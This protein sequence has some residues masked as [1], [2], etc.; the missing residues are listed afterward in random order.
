MS[1]TPR[2]NISDLEYCSY[3]TIRSFPGFIQLF[4]AKFTTIAPHS[5]VVF[6][7]QYARHVKDELS[8]NKHIYITWKVSEKDTPTVTLI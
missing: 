7:L 5:L 6:Q 1:V 4:D 3:P 2:G 8:I